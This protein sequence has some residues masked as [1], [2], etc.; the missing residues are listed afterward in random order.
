MQIIRTVED[1]QDMLRHKRREASLRSKMLAYEQMPVGLPY[2]VKTVET[3][4]EVRLVFFTEAHARALFSAGCNSGSGEDTDGTAAE[5]PGS[6][7]HP[8]HDGGDEQ[9]P[10]AE[11]GAVCELPQE[12]RV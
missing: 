10:G 1:V 6:D 9:R 3:Q 8:Q 4:T 2:L 11:A 5:K 12:P 7:D